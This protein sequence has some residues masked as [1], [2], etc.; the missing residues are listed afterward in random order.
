MTRRKRRLGYVAVALCIA[1]QSALAV[2]SRVPEPPVAEDVA[3]ADAGPYTLTPQAGA[4]APAPSDD[5]AGDAALRD[6][7]DGLAALDPVA[8]GRGEDTRVA[9]PSTLLLVSVG[10]FGL[11]LWTRRR[12]R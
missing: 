11:I 9:E 4:P 2:P 6:A 1:T 8:R 5:F 12:R 10:L 7:L 3:R